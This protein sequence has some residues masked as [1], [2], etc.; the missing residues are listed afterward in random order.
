MRTLIL[1]TAVALSAAVASPAWAHGH[2]ESEKAAASQAYKPVTDA[3]AGVYGLDLTHASLTWRVMHLGLARY[4]ARFAKFDSTLEIDPAKP[5]A[6]KLTVTIDPTSIRT[7]YPNAAT[8]D[9]DKA[10]ATEER[11]FNA[12][13]FPT[14][15]FASTKIERTGERT[16]K[17]TGDL[18]FLG[19]TKPTTLDVTFN[20]GMASH[21]FAKVGAIGFSATGKL[22]RSDF[23]MTALLP[24]IGD[25]VDLQIEVEY[26]QKKS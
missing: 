21:P 24:G 12:G 16:A 2:K 26:I 13:K 10:L 23:G 7:D 9:F 20:G 4:T 25:E 17:V 22:K 5:E 14:I 8:K 18:N 11:W 1:A 6:A 19:V 15:T 3:P